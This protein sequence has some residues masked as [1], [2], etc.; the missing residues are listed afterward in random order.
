MQLQCAAGFTTIFRPIYPSPSLGSHCRVGRAP[1]QLEWRNT[2]STRRMMLCASSYSTAD[3]GNYPSCRM[4]K[5][6]T[7]DALR[8]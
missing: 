5:H 3:P 1:H 4:P 6:S 8:S 7:A 2:S